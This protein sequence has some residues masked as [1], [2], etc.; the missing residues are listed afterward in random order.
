MRDLISPEKS[1]H[2]ALRSNAPPNALS[3][4]ITGAAAAVTVGTGTRRNVLTPSDWLELERIAVHLASRD[5]LKIVVFRGAGMTFSA[6]SD[7]R[8]WAGE[9]STRIDDD[10]A[11]IESALQ[12]IEGIPLPTVA[13]VEGVAAGAGCELALAC[14][15]RI[16]SQ[17]AQIGLPIVQLG[18]LVSPHFSLRL[19]LLVGV[20]RARELL[21]TGRLVSAAEADRMGMATAVIAEEQVHTELARL[22]A[23][24]SR[25]PRLGLVAAKA[26]SSVALRDMRAQHE[27][28]GWI[29]SDPDELPGRIEAFLAR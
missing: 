23:E 24:I 19:T 7:L 2:G 29:F 10:F 11:R 6:G 3:L 25:Q 20:S 13:V 16:F 12:A 8:Y 15:L 1:W 22:V 17:S 28:P 18:V 9:E 14:D 26:A 21:Y 27:V 5:D 4:T